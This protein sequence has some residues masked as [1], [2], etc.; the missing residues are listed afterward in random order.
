MT[1][2]TLV[3]SNI[4]LVRYEAMCRAIAEAHAIDEVKLIRDQAAA[5]AAAAKIARNQIA[6]RQCLENP[7]PRPTRVGVSP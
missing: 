1:Q 7:G 6:L 4:T 5:L 2:L 3:S